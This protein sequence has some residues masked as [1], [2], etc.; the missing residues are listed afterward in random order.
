MRNAEVIRQWKILRTL[1]AQ[2]L[3]K[4]VDALALQLN[5]GKRTVWRDMA[6]LQEA[7]FPLTSELDGRRTRWKLAASP[8]RGL[9]ELGLSMMDLCALYMA[10]TMVDGMAGAPFGGA[11]AAVSRQ[12][13]KTLPPKMRAFLDQ[14][15]S[16][17][18]AKPGAVKRPGTKTYEDHVARLIEASADRR[19]A[20]MRYF[21]S[22]RG[23]AKDYVIHP[24]RL[25]HAHGGLYLLAWVPEYGEIRTFAV[26]RIQKL[27]LGEE[28]FEIQ[29]ELAP[30]AFAHS[31]GVNQGKPIR[32]VVSF[33][34]RIASYV[35]ERTWHA[36]QKF[37]NLADGGLRMVLNVSADAALRTWILGFGAFAKVESPSW[38]AE[39]I[40]EQLEQAREGYVPRL[41]ISLPQR[42]FLFDHPVLPGLPPPR[43]S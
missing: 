39:E 35:R 19:Q 6:A 4:T 27:S 16:L 3:G 21:S 24:Y 1:D 22:S 33:Q 20:T 40:L 7:G 12:I 29:A 2:R 9:A 25:V 41:D 37:T 11:L 32:V 15:P 38:L 8:F 17:V 14:L 26:E 5:V 30:E 28:R 18:E 10:R 34:P 31:L 42:V 43:P 36:S 13:E 23:A